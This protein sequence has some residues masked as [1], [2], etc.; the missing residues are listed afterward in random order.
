[1]VAYWSHPPRRSVQLGE[2]E[3]TDLSEHEGGKLRGREV[4]WLIRVGLS[5]KVRVSKIRGLVAGTA[6]ARRAGASGRQ[7][8]RARRRRAVRDAALGRPLAPGAGAGE[9]FESTARKDQRR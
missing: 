6:G 2:V 7:D 1:V 8:A 5:E 9:V 3:L 4:V